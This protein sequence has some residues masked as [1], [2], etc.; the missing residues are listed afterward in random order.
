MK[1]ILFFVCMLMCGLSYAEPLEGLVCT[2]GNIKHIYQG[3]S[4][5]RDIVYID[6]QSYTFVK[7]HTVG[8]ISFTEFSNDTD[9]N[10]LAFIEVDV[11]EDSNGTQYAKLVMMRRGAKETSFGGLCKYK[12]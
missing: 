8:D 1:I 2:D 12:D 5:N 10:F 6:G 4:D 3:D 9:P 7:E 11:Y